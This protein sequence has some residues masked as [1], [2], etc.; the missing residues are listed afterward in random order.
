MKGRPRGGGSFVMFALSMRLVPRE[1][2]LVPALASPN[3]LLLP[4]GFP[5]MRCA[6]FADTK[7][8]IELPATRPSRQAERK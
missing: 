7:L 4:Y 5:W 6:T 8:P 3:G 1:S 2:L